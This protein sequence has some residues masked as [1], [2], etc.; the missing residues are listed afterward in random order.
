MLFERINHTDKLDCIYTLIEF[1]NTFSMYPVESAVILCVKYYSFRLCF[2]T[3]LWK[4]YQKREKHIFKRSNIHSLNLQFEIVKNNWILNFENWRKNSIE[5]Y[6]NKVGKSLKML[7][8]INYNYIQLAKFNL[9][10]IIPRTRVQIRGQI[11][12]DFFTFL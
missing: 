3:Y 5:G 4:C 2:V 11:S 8:W 1:V 6:E 12:S 10:V 9:F 7:S